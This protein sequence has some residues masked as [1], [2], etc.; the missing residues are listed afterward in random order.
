MAT[1]RSFALFRTAIGLC[2]IAWSADGVIGVQL[3]EA[4]EYMTRAR[5][6]GRFPGANESEPTTEVQRAIDAIVALLRGEKPDLTD[7]ALDMDRVPEFEQRVFEMARTIPPGTTLSYG[8]VAT[9][10]G[11]PGTARAVGQALGRNPFPIIVPCHR[12]VAA[13]GKMHGFSAPGG[14]VTKLRLLSIEGWEPQGGPMLFDAG[15]TDH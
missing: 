6:R 8:D 14:V 7:I 13:D 10:L 9:R 1:G 12:V 5:M 3:P 4:D 15:M 2:G 11:E